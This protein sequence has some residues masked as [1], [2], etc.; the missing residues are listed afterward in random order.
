MHGE[1]FLLQSMSRPRKRRSSPAVANDGHAARGNCGGKL[2]KG[3]KGCPSEL[4]R[5]TSGS[6]PTKNHLEQM[7]MDLIQEA[8]K[9][10]LAPKPTCLWWTSTYDSEEKIDLSMDPKTG[11]HRFPFEVKFKI[12]GCAMNCEQ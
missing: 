9:W 12:L 4:G 1:Q 2:D 7:L 5:T 8:E 11:R 6:C 10:D 3:K